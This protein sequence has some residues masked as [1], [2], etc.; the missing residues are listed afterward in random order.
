[1][2]F[3][4]S[5]KKF[6]ENPAALTFVLSLP[7]F[8]AILISP[9]AS[10]LSDRIWTRVGRRKPFI[11]A[12]WIGMV[13]AMVLMPL[14]PNVWLLLSAFILYNLSAD[15]NSPMEPL[16]QEIIPPPQRAR[17][18]GAM[19]WL[20]NLATMTFYFIMLGR[21]DDVSFLAGLPIHGEW[22]VYW[23]AA[24]LLAVLLLVIML[25]IR[26]INPQSSLRGQRLTVRTFFGGLL[27]REL[28][29][30][31]LLV[32]G[33]AC[34]NFYAGLG[35][36]SNLLYTDQWG[37]TKQEMGVNVAVGGILNVFIIG[38]LTVFAGRLNRMRAYQT[39]L[40]LSLLGNIFYYCYIEFVLPDKHPTLIEI[41]VFGESLS[42]LAILA[43]LLY[44]PLVYD[45]VRRNRM[46][47]FNAGASIVTKL[48]TLITLNGVGL[49]ASYYAE[50]F[51]PPAGE[52]MRV[53]LRDNIHRSELLSLLKSGLWPSETKP[54]GLAANV[55]QANG[56]TGESGRTWEIRR[57]NETSATLAKKKNELEAERSP[58][59]S[60]EAMA[61]EAS[62]QERR[63]GAY[64]AAERNG[65]TAEGYRGRISDVA[66]SIEGIEGE[67]STRANGFRE[68]VANVLRDRV[69]VEGDQIVSAA[70]GAALIVD[71]PVTR[72]PEGMVLEKMLGDLRRDNPAVIDLRP[73]KGQGGYALSISAL[74][75]PDA[76]LPVVA[77]QLQTATER[78]GAKRAPGLLAT[79][80]APLGSQVQPALSVDLRVVEQPVD[81]YVSPIT[82]VVNA[83]LRLFDRAPSPS[84]R[85]SA[86]ARNLRTPETN[87]VRAT[88]GPGD[89]TISVVAV[90]GSSVSVPAAT[91][92]LVNIRL[93]ALLGANPETVAR[94]R[95]FCDRIEK[96]AA[97][98]RITVVHPVLAAAYAP[99]RYDYMSGYL[100]MFVMGTIGIALTL[101]FGRL[102]ANGVIHKRGV[103][104]ALA[105]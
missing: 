5:L 81:I 66:Q 80:T 47:T 27:E 77:S 43:G 87:H 101:C 78:L 86:L 65:H 74:V 92:D 96:S 99:L 53:V 54:A 61:R 50:A 40:C 6:I 60:K 63:K 88:L 52:M 35:T 56:V 25:G 73:L 103:E 46:G 98:Q 29:P 37:Y 18:T 67:L 9:L 94:A 38:L 31:Y 59:L 4:F 14:M 82:R 70:S 21:F 85:L 90:V 33:N 105:S 28:W 7:V 84:R 55:W 69:I 24:L 44:I 30:V 39:T 95:A 57:R 23:S 71:L 64:A 26:E 13:V 17:A 97:T 22:V 42:V 48:A 15:L 34:L 89:H 102:E 19:A 100:W 75:A 79:G 68:Q 11:I 32:F 104:E 3:L 93:T 8:L 36:L 72:R 20:S 76:D 16:K 83:G 12:S 45:Y 2:A 91:D 49:F 1:M 58:L 41:I 62:V 51:Q 10:F